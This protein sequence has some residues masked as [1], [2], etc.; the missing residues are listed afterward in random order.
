MV[1]VKKIFRVVVL[2]FAASV[3]VA[4]GAS[5]MTQDEAAG[6]VSSAR[7]GQLEVLIASDAAP[8]LKVTIYKE[9]REQLEDRDD[10]SAYFPISPW[11]AIQA[12]VPWEKYAIAVETTDDCPEGEYFSVTISPPSTEDDP[13]PSVDCYDFT[14]TKQDE[15]Q[16]SKNVVIADTEFLWEV[17]A[18]TAFTEAGGDAAIFREQPQEGCWRWWIIS[19]NVDY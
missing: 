1:K 5:A 15:L 9:K 13:F 2:A 19:D 18:K 11:M 14:K 8:G 3:F 16:I 12:I 4:G 7:Q 10:Q 6:Y 17:T